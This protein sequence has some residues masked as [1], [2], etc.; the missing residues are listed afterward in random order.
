MAVE[1]ISLYRDRPLNR[2][3]ILNGQAYMH[4]CMRSKSDLQAVCT[5]AI[6]VEEVMIWEE[7]DREKEGGK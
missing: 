7:L 4:V 6:V 5:T 1:R 3:P 2:N